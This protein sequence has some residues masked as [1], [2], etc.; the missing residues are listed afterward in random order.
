M[1]M[2]SLK[3]QEKGGNEG[4]ASKM[5][6]MEKVRFKEVNTLQP[7]KRQGFEPVLKVLRRVRKRK[8][9]LV[10]RSFITAFVNI[11]VIFFSFHMCQLDKDYF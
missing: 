11:K 8:I 5:L 7:A 6:G 2:S 3:C 10:W 9:H 4:V 1:K